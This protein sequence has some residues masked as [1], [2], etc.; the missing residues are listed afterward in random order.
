MSFRK[1]L[2]GKIQCEISKLLRIIYEN[3]QRSRL[4]ND[5]F[6]IICSNCV[7]GVIY[8][9][10]GKRFL[11]PTINLW[12]HQQEFIKFL[13]DMKGYL[14]EELVFVDSQYDYP[15]A[16][17]RDIRVYFA[18]YHT[19]EEAR[20]A[21]VRRKAR[22]NYDNLYIIMYD[23]DGI[24]R[25]DLLKL[26]DIHCKGKAVFSEYVRNYEGIDYLYTLKPHRRENGALFT[27]ADWFGFK[28]FEKRFDFVKFLNS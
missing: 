9:R 10:L 5:N 1:K 3:I 2:T 24:T 6:S 18:H 22:I 23:R 25:E 19:R 20:D 7:G 4:K 27:Y 16:Q 13:L 14:S 8:N 12:F 21:W 15:V 28:T 11:S 26:K 17:L